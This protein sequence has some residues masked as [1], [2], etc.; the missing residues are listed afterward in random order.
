V[1]P[2]TYTSYYPGEFTVV[3][4]DEWQDS[5]R[6]VHNDILNKAEITLKKHV[7]VK[8]KRMMVEGRSGSKIVEVANKEDVNLIV[9]GNRGI[10]GLTGYILGSTSHYVVDH[11]EKPVLVIK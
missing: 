4:I 11:C 10:G 6:K 8:Y 9:I 7:E 2:H 3:N 1:T 5:L